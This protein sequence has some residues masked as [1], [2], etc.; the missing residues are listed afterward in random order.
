MKYFFIKVFLSLFFASL[1]FMAES[2]FTPLSEQPIL[3]ELHQ[4]SL[5]RP[6]FLGISPSFEEFME[7]GYLVHTGEF[8]RGIEE[9]KKKPSELCIK[10]SSQRPSLFWTFNHLIPLEGF[11][12]H[13]TALI[14]FKNIWPQ[15]VS[16]GFNEVMT[17]GDYTLKKGDILILSPDV[18]SDHGSALGVNLRASSQNHLSKEELE[19]LFSEIGIDFCLVRG[20]LKTSEDVKK[21]NQDLSQIVEELLRKKNGWVVSFP[22]E[23]DKKSWHLTQE[24]L[25]DGLPILNDVFF[26]ILLNHQPKLRVGHS[27][28]SFLGYQGNFQLFEEI[29]LLSDRII[30]SHLM[31]KEEKDGRSSLVPS[32]VPGQPYG[33]SC[34]MEFLPLYPDFYRSLLKACETMLPATLAEL[35][36]SKENSIH[37]FE[38]IKESKSFIELVIP[39]SGFDM[40]FKTFIDSL[41]SQ[42]QSKHLFMTLSDNRFFF[43]SHEEFVLCMKKVYLS[44]SNHGLQHGFLADQLDEGWDYFIVNVLRHIS[45]PMFDEVKKTWE[46]WNRVG[47]EK[48]R[49]MTSYFHLLPELKK[50]SPLWGYEIDPSPLSRSDLQ[51]LQDLPHSMKIGLYFEIFYHNLSYQEDFGFQDMK[52][53]RTIQ[54][55][56]ESHILT[57]I[58]NQEHLHNQWALVPWKS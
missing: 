13:G 39:K 19:S 45:Q 41:E 4:T 10:V 7:K 9:G 46:G 54:D 2:A 35:N 44:A 58:Q 47:V 12:G 38:K 17:M 57:F 33:G 15:I 37:L 23:T 3:Y 18:I 21:P 24:F 30:G 40:F 11:W 14:R 43:K 5:S 48:R 32:Y 31:V 56:I 8:A 20:S 55:R 52:K 22:E 49:F 16:V 29:Y 28:F 53:A 36:I 50:R 51:A 26:D 42:Y 34:F 1:A 6:H 25:V 27:T